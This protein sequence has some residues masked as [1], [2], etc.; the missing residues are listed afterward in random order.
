MTLDIVHPDTVQLL[1]RWKKMRAAGIVTLTGDFS[2]VTVAQAFG[3]LLG[4][5]SSPESMANS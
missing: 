5:R 1:S 2:T 4:N 3:D